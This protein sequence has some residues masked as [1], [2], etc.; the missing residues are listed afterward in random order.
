MI[1]VVNMI[2]QSMSGETNQ[3]S[4]PNLAVNPADLHQL[5]ATAFTPAPMGG[6][7]APV[8][9]SSDAGATWA[10]NTIVPGN[11]PFGTSDISVAFPTVGGTLYGGTLNGSTLDLNILRTAAPFEPTPMTVLVDRDSEDQP[12]V[13]AMSSEGRDRVFVGNNDRA[14]SQS[15]T[16]DL[17][18]DAAT[19]LPPRVRPAQHRASFHR[20]TGRAAHKA[21]SRGRRDRLRGP[22]ALYQ[23]HVRCRHHPR[24][25]CQQGRRR[26][27]FGCPVQQAHRLR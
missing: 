7:N 13:V 6:A 22:S 8:Y 15:A 24:R 9:V 27:P 23:P 18:V 10:L 1:T 2:P 20:R 19:A 26:G 5:V 16:V 12:W 11:G 3:D 17:S 21:R 4:E 14:S 25:G